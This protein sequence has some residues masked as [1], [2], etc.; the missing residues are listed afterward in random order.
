[1][2]EK[3]NVNQ[4][5]GQD[6]S[7]DILDSFQAEGF[8]SQNGQDQGSKKA[9]LILANSMPW[10]IS[11]LFHVGLFLVMFFLVFMIVRQPQS[12]D[13]IIPD[14]V[15]SKTPGGVM[16]PR[17]SEMKSPTKSQ[18]RQRKQFKRTTKMTV[19]AGKTQKA[20]SIL[21]PGSS[22][23]SSSASDLGLRTSGG[24]T[25]SRFFGTGG[26]A[27]NI[28]YVIDFSGSMVDTFDDVRNE[29]LKSIGR[30][31]SKQTFHIILFTSGKPLEIPPGRLISATMENKRKAA[32]FLKDVTPFT[33]TNPIPAL[34]R[35]FAV[36]KGANK[37][38]KLIYLLTD[39][40]F[41][42]SVV[43]EIRQLNEDKKVL[44]NTYLYV[45]DPPDAP[46]TYIDKVKR[47]KSVMEQIA[48][49][50]GGKYKFVEYDE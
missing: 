16:T 4:K 29:I 5:Q 37:Q 18:S 23:L 15:M 7:P 45:Y 24:G 22:A 48:K 11:L 34:E 38:G 19:D 35:A 17:P 49:E 40:M 20:L 1:M 21:S 25:K 46:V 10:V 6:T 39:G 28:V 41:S 31:N 33:R 12:E 50:N 42:D 30:L 43:S 3:E 32:K 13:I 26:N 36:L 27:H 14:A 44:I 9:M 47:F 2:P 8:P